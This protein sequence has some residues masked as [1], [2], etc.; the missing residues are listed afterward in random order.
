MFHEIMQ[1]TDWWKYMASRHAYIYDKM[2]PT[3]AVTSFKLVS[4]DDTHL[5]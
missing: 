1:A 5:G 2:W 4:R 3:Y